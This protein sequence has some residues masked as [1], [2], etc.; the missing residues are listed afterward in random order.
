MV[1]EDVVGK[2]WFGL[3]KK[4][5]ANSILPV[6]VE[7]RKSFEGWLKVEICELLQDYEYKV[8]PENNHIDVTAGHLAIELKTIPTNYAWPGVPHSHA[9]RI[10]AYINEVLTDAGKLR[11]ENYSVRMVNFIAY[12]LSKPHKHYNIWAEDHLKR[13]RLHV[14]ELIEKPFEFQKGYPGIAYFGHVE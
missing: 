13:I 11:S 7:Q 6:F 1:F 9:K 2:I 3:E 14:S 8:I 12:P 4:L 10:T 5:A